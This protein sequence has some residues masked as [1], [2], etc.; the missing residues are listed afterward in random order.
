MLGVYGGSRGKGPAPTSG[1]LKSGY[2]SFWALAAATIYSCRIF[3]P[4]NVALA[5]L[6]SLL[7]SSTVMGCKENQCSG[8]YNW[9]SVNTPHIHIDR[10]CVSFSLT[11][12]QSA[13]KG[14]MGKLCWNGNKATKCFFHCC[15]V[16]MIQAHDWLP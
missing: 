1:P 4:V 6:R 9:T 12:S 10:F 7:A 2:G 8:K 16:H 15:G 5:F 13:K 11:F 3:F 14:R